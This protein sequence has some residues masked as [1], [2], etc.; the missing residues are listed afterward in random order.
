MTTGP[1][2]RVGF[3]LIELLVVIAIMAVL[4]GLLLPAVQ[5]AREAASRA[6]CINNLS[7]LTKG[8]HNYHDSNGR[9]PPNGTVSFYVGI[10]SF[11]EQTNNDASV[12]V[13]IFTCP[14]RRQPGAYCDYVGAAHYG[15]YTQSNVKYSY[16]WSGTTYT[17]TYTYDVTPKVNHAALGG[18]ERVTLTTIT[19]L[20]GASN[21]LLLGE[22]AVS[23]QA[24]GGSSPADLN[25]DKVGSF[26][27]PVYKAQAFNTSY[28][29]K[30]GN[31]T[32][33]YTYTYVS[34]VPD[35]SQPMQTANTKRGLAQYGY[36]N[37][38][39][40]RDRDLNY[41]YSQSD[42]S[43]YFGTAHAYGLMPA[44]FCDGSVRTVKYQYVPQQMISYDDN[45]PIPSYY[46]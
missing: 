26:I 34:Y 4:I 18:D 42:A 11:V 39:V 15:G 46:Q 32:Y 5:K 30:S 17:Y 16:G 44:G 7:Q 37:T 10:K 45:Q 25:W 3:T 41:S 24:Y 21:T 40:Y 12:A 19:N 27:S 14:S 33:N 13:K 23:P 28:S 22:K 43:T 20:D 1:R 31:Y 35:N 36:P 2:R 9:M 6:S 29:F 38:Y 8:I